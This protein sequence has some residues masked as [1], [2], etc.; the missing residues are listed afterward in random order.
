ME[1]AS[2]KCSRVAGDEIKLLQ[3]PSARGNENLYELKSNNQKEIPKHFHIFF[4]VP[5]SKFTKFILN[6][7]L[8]MTKDF[9]VNT[10]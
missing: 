6:R 10:K 1:D 8:M 5:C 2:R 4:I 9:N 7:M 3:K